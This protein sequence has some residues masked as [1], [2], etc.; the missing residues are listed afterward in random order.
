MDESH[1]KINKDD[2]FLN[3]VQSLTEW[4]QVKWVKNTSAT[5]P[6]ELIAPWPFDAIH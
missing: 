1:I 6:E 2:I 5:A 3:K 4:Q